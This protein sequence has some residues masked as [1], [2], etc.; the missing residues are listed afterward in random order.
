MILL[1][2]RIDP[3]K[4]LAGVHFQVT[5]ISRRFTG[6]DLLWRRADGYDLPF[7]I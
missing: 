1:N 6:L 3:A 5:Q 7:R 2:Q 4:T